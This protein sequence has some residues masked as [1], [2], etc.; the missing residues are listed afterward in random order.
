MQTPLEHVLAETPNYTF[1]R[2]FGYACWPH[3]RPYNNRKLQFHSKQ[4]VFLGYNSV[5]KR[6]KC[7]HIPSYRLYISHNVVFDETIFPFSQPASESTLPSSFTPPIRSDQFVD[8]AYTL[9][10]VANHGA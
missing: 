9:Y 8:A 5:H 3:L 6:Y 7:L 4:C 2:V 10:L 1:F